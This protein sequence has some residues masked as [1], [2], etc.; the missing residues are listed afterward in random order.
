VVRPSTTSTTTQPTCGENPS[1][2]TFAS[3]DC[4]IDALLARLAGEPQLGSFAAKLSHN[5]QAAKTR[6]LGAEDA[7]RASSLKKT[8][9]HLQQATRAFTQYVHRLN[10]L[11]A[12]KKLDP[13]V[14]QTFLDDGTS[15]QQALAALRNAVHCPDD[16]L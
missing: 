12:R 2:P 8:K 9:K 15:I 6:K 4:Q 13:T 3:V 16:A 1:A 5:V 7:C 14:R 10:G 11:A